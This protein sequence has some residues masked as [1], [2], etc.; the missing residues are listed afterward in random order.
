MNLTAGEIASA[1]GGVLMCDGNIKINGIS[2]DSRKINKGTAF[3]ALKGEN[4]DGH[5]FV[6]DALKK[7]AALAV[8]SE[9]R[10]KKDIIKVDDTLAALGR[11]AKY[12]KAKF[13][14]KTIAVTGSVGKTTSKDMIF[15]VLSQKYKTLATRGNFNNNIGLPLTVFG[16]NDEYEAAVLEMG[17][18]GFG[19]IHYLAGIGRPDT[20][21]ITNIGLSHIEKLGSREGIL[22]AKMEICDFF[23][24]NST[25]IINA[26]DDLL[27][28][29]VDNKQFKVISFGIKNQNADFIARE[30]ND[31][32]IDGVE[33]S[34]VINNK[35]HKFNVK[36]AGVH[37]VYNALA[38]ICAGYHY[39]VDIEGIKYGIE[40]YTLTD[41]RM[42]IENI[43]DITIINDCYNASPASVEAGLKVLAGI[44][45]ERRIAVLGD[46]LEMGDYSES[47]HFNA[48]R[49]A[50]MYA[51]CLL[52]AGKEAENM[53]KGA[54]ETGIKEVYT[55]A[56]SAELAEFAG[57]YI[58]AGDAVLIKAS[59][60]MR[61]EVIYNTLKE[62][63]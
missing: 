19:E 13:K 22:K 32:G 49:Q 4:F 12:Y 21:V 36:T 31:M 60:G 52:C 20:A 50:G 41:M 33:F 45:A 62:K 18:S 14:V 15:S 7:G 27:Y 9:D 47:A 8:V 56:S 24:E 1:C 38:A 34:V 61:F 23:D 5:G 30:I 63:I 2:T 53:K 54:N 35:K 42:N 58:K 3:I 37:N 48:G 29:E 57:D 25:L 46:M 6:E 10:D 59:R 51:D 16:M 43:K 40:E 28:K 55:F 11:I 17:M 44:K 39:G 26:D